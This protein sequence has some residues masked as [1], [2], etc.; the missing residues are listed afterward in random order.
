MLF[1]II[2][3]DDSDGFRVVGVI[4]ETLLTLVFRSEIVEDLGS[5]AVDLRFDA[6]VE[7]VNL[8]SRGELS[9]GSCFGLVGLKIG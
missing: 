9:Y 1:D 8:V 6:V 7:R 2:L 5:F 3:D 4:F